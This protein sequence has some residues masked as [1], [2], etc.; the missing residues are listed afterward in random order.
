MNKRAYW[1]RHQD[2]FQWGELFIYVGIILAIIL[3]GYGVHELGKDL[4]RGESIKQF[5]LDN[6][7]ERRYT[8]NGERFCL[9]KTNGEF[10]QHKVYVDDDGTVGFLRDGGN[11]R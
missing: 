11:G 3:F 7:L 1:G 9:E 5:C 8:E 10:I 6:N 4:E 2:E